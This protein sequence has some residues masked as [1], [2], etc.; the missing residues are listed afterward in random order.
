VIRVLSLYTLGLL[1]ACQRPQAVSTHTARAGS[2]AAGDRTG[3]TRPGREVFRDDRPECPDACSKLDGWDCR[4]NF[5]RSCVLECQT[6]GLDGWG[7]GVL[8]AQTPREVEAALKPLYGP[9][10]C[11][12]WIIP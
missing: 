1:A 7:P 12:D 11:G 2:T 10:A 6:A 5:A 4:T 9:H 3:T 8:A